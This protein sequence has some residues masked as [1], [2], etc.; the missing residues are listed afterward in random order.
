MRLHYLSLHEPGGYATAGYRLMRAL[1]ECGVGVRWIPFVSGSGLGPGFGYQPGDAGDVAE[2]AL[3]DLLEGPRECDAVVAHLVPEY[4]PYVRALYPDVPLIG[5]TV[6]ETDRL[7]AHW[8][9][10]LD[11]AHLVIVPTAWNADTIRNSRVSAPVEVVPHAAA[12]PS[13]AD[14]S[15]WSE[16]PHEATVFYSIAPWTVRKALPLTVR[17]YQLAFAG[18]DD[19]M[20]VLKTSPDDQTREGAPMRL[21]AG[22]GTSAWALA[23]LLHETPDP[24]PVRLVTRTLEEEDVAA[25]HTRGDCYV[26][27]CHAEGWGIPPFDAAT[28]R[29]PVVITAFGGQLEYLDSG[30][31][32]LVDYDLVP[33][34]DPVGGRS[35]TPDQRWAR[36][37]LEHAA[38]LLRQVLAE[39]AEAAARA[40]RASRRIQSRYNGATVAATFLAAL[41]RWIDAPA[42]VG[43]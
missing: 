41:G 10:L 32:F 36:P 15:A 3:R 30:S 26:S 28:R 8:P 27:L 12:R 20:L 1:R 42:S 21:P 17:A 22:P 5:H 7:P 31:A 23:R 9:R 34:D 14:S 40:E 19:T 4:W 29:T 25:L 43:P 35:Y 16:I 18:R 37:S 11:E 13:A 33:V 39:P 6:W 24:A 2:P 38:E